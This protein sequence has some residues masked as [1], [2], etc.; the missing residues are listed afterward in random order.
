MRTVGWLTLAI[1]ALACH[2]YVVFSAWSGRR[3]R[4]RVSALR[5]SLLL[6]ALAAIANADPRI[7]ARVNDLVPSRGTPASA[8]VAAGDTAFS[9]AL[10]RQHPQWPFPSGQ[11]SAAVER[12]RHR[13]VE[14]LR[15]QTGVVADVAPSVP[16]K[17]VSSERVGSVRRSLVT[18]TSWDGT[19][20]PAYV[21]DPDGGARKAAVLVVAGHGS[22]I[23][24]TAGL[25]DDYQHAAALELAR[26]GYLTLTPELRGFGLLGVGGAANHRSVSAA[27]LAAGTSYKAVVVRDLGRAL[28]VLERWPGV[29]PRR[30]AVAGTSLGGELAVLLGALDPRVRVVLSHSYGG[31]VGPMTVKDDVPDDAEQTPHGCHTIPGV[32]RIL[33]QED[34]SRLVAPRPLLVVR[35]DSDTPAQLD[36]FDR[37]VREAYWAQGAAD[38]F[39]L[40]IERGKHEFYLE[41]S[42]RFLARWL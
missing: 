12:W 5:Y 33:F 3:P 20:I 21:H 35:G 42:V 23:T 29:D 4:F 14:A 22:G 17:V 25:V 15:D 37:R 1:A 31:S 38:R 24:A 8:F 27:A 9:N 6:I 28:T 30:L 36:T 19:A 41:P 40:S 2:E 13:V 16:L 18:F 10:A 39:V 26:Q 11:S 34:W 32:N 7:L